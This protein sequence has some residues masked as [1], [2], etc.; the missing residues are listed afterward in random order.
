VSSLP[1]E[2]HE[3][4]ED[5][6]VSMYGPLDQVPVEYTTREAE[7]ADDDTVEQIVDVACAASILREWGLGRDGMSRV[8]IVRKLNGFI[9]NLPKDKLAGWRGLS[10]AG[11]TLMERYDELAD[12]ASRQGRR[13][14]LHRRIIDDAFDD[15]VQPL[16]DLRTARVYKALHER[17]KDP[18]KEARTALCISGGGIRSATF[19]LG[20]MQGLASAKV[21][22]KFDFLST[23]SGGGYIGSWL[24]SWAR[25]HPHGISGV[26]EDLARSDTAAGGTRSAHAGN[27]VDPDLPRPRDRKIEP[28]PVPLRHLREYSNYLSP[29]MG[30]LSGDSWTMGALYLRNLLLN[31]MVLVP[32]FAA[33]LFVPRAYA[34]LST[35]T[36]AL[37]EWIYPSATVILI[38][39][40]FAYIGRK[41]P[42]EDSA[43]EPQKNTSDGYFIRGCILPLLGASIMLTLFWTDVALDPDELNDKRLLLL[44]AVAA[45]SMTVLPFVLYYR[46][47]KVAYTQARSMAYADAATLKKHLIKKAALEAFG[48]VLGLGTA[49]GLIWLLAIKVFDQPLLGFTEMLNEAQSVAPALRVVS[50]T[51]W[52]SIYTVF[53]VPAV[54][55]VFFIQASI[56]VGISSKRN[57]DYDREWWGRAGAWVLVFAAG[58]AVLSG[59]AVFGPVAIYNA[60]VLLGSIGGLSG[61]AAG[62]LGFSGKTPANKK[63][64]EDAGATAKAG[65]AALGL[66]TPLFVLF[67]LAL[68][69]LGTTWL[70]QE[71]K[72]DI[73]Y[74][75]ASL[76]SR[77]EATT[78]RVRAESGLSV[79]T[80]AAS[81]AAPAVSLTEL[82]S[83]NHLDTVYKTTW[84][85]ILV[86]AI[87]AGFAWFLSRRIG[88]NKFSMHALYRNRL[89][90]AYLGASRYR[91]QPNPFTGFDERDNL[92]MF[93]LRPELLWPTNLRDPA[94]FFKA[95]QEGARTTQ[96]DLSGD[97]L[98]RRKLAQHLWSRFYERT[99]DQVMKGVNTVSID[100]VIQNLNDI[101]LDENLLE[102]EA[103]LNLPP[104]FWTRCEEGK[105]PYP[106]AT[107]NRAVLDYYFSKVITPM[108]RPKDAPSDEKRVEVAGGAS[109]FL[110]TGEGVRRRAPLHVINM[111]LNLVSGEKL[112]WQQRMAETFTT[113]PYHTGN[114]FLG[115]RDSRHYGGREGISVGG[116]VTISGAAASPNM[117][118]HS[119]PAL[120][121]LLTLFNIRL[122]SWLG[123]P[124]PAGQDTY[125]AEHPDSNLKPILFEAIGRTND[126]YPWVYL[127]DGGHFE[128]LGLY[129]MVLRRCHYI[130]LSDGGADPKCTFEDLGNAIRKIRTD[131]GVPI[132]IE[133]TFMLPRSDNSMDKE[134]RYVATATIRY[135]AIDGQD[136]VD[137][138]LIYLKPGVYKDEYFPRDV[139]NY[140]LD[141]TDFPHEPTSDQ[142]F[143]ESQ[144]ESYR[145]LGR[146][147]IN[148]ICGNYPDD[149][150][151]WQIP[152]AKQYDSVAHFAT[153]VQKRYDDSA[154]G[155]LPPAKLIASAIRQ[156]RP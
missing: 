64:K 109:K 62:L 85:E 110:E 33:V 20:V 99:C 128:N 73:D 17:A 49:C 84:W 76:D 148:Q 23:V 150:D 70:T 48:A 42:V 11:R 90:R 98:E 153:S 13:E 24:S 132:D 51:P 7:E 21:L 6:Y 134:G 127:S 120:A 40:A 55:L 63:E 147:A 92:H 91:R 88:V 44:L 30:I 137:G 78:K 142:F 60:P 9:E 102:K 27:D 12:T 123:N 8:E 14:E 111:A 114:V 121:F 152:I 16:R 96:T 61:L 67:F 116:A 87:V 149:A 133:E 139:Y 146:H 136:A 155:E 2:V 124:G 59:V 56:F 115:Y 81:A 54:M 130:V 26:Q 4:L 94:R 141:S 41:R 68:I 82:R 75:Q 71:L 80:T 46:R 22:D 156:L 58:W 143:S 28:E 66:A 108:T 95:L 25:R 140:A 145:A 74:R 10:N 69:S 131:L 105:I 77:Y 79:E 39:I 34:Y 57:E 15:A 36:L 31:L 1:R 32:I 47:L 38:A 119:S 72:Y 122:G 151:K 65:N 53:A 118:Y 3:V 103:D 104:D 37:H 83:L 50:T 89:I 154:V 126:T 5:E 100:G 45:L 101:I 43:A 35:T 144:F 129:E 112:A 19:A 86:V 18:S 29:R 113:S 106:A 97:P 52:A 138:T 107:R 117:G 125:Q 135:K 93:Q